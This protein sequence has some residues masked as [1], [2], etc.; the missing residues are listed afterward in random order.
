[1]KKAEILEKAR[2]EKNQEY[3]EGIY[4]EILKQSWLVVV[5]LCIFFFITKVVYADLHQ[6]EYSNAHEFPAF[7]LGYTA[8]IY[9][10][11]YRKSKEQTNLWIGLVAL[12]SSI[13]FII[14]Y[15]MSW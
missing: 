8:F 9:L 2:L 6:L 12:L 7:L 14:A 15:F 4:Q 5:I 11:L 10:S 1:M 13:G 3:E